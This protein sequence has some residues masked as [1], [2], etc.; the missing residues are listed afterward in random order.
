MWSLVD[1]LASLCDHWTMR[2]AVIGGGVV[3]AACACALLDVADNV[4][5]LEAG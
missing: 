2:V 5:L 4:V 3:G 1:A